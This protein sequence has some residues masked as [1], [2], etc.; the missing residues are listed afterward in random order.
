MQKVNNDVTLEF[1]TG[2]DVPQA[3]RTYVPVSHRSIIDSI[4]EQ[5]DKLGF[6]IKNESYLS[7]KQGTQMLG[8]FGFLTDDTTMGT[9]LAFRNSYDKSLSIKVITGEQLWICKNGS[10]IG[11]D[12]NYSKKHVSDVNVLTPST[13]SEYINSSFDN[14]EKAI[15]I[16][17]RM[18]EIELSKRTISTLVGRMFLEDSV[19]NTAQLAIIKNELISP[20]FNYEADNSLWEFFNHT[21]YSLKQ[22]HP[23]TYMNQQVKLKKFFQDEYQLV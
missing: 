11:S 10:M 19:I 17:E 20:T 18:K 23:M 3:T 22:N 8:R 9:E 21:T 14:F 16:R 5:S 1:L 2:I 13:I 7:N 6:Q 4:K 15:K 12:N